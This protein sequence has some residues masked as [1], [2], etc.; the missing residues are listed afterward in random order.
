V[1]ELEVEDLSGQLEHFRATHT[2]KHY[3]VNGRTW[4]YLLGGQRNK[5]ALLLLPG[6]PGLGEMAFQHIMKFEHSYYV[7]SPNYP[8]GLTTVD[9]VIDD[10]VAIL[11]HEEIDAAHIVG[12]S[13]SGMITQC[14]L[15][16][17]PQRVRKI[18]L[19]HTSP[20]SKKMT[21]MYILYY[22]ILL[23][24]PLFCIRALLRLGNYFFSGR[25]T[26]QQA[27]WHSYFER[28]IIGGLTKED[29]LS[30]ARVCI[31][32]SRNYS[33]TS[34]DVHF[35]PGT[36][37]IIESDNDSFVPEEERARLKA[38]YPSARI[39]TFYGTGHVAWRNQS[40]TFFS[41]IASFLQE[42]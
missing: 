14:F 19:D 16:C 12:G 30:R 6:V 36:L 8:A 2:F 35:Q 3:N 7:I 39:Y 29:Y 21:R 40:D 18:V 13:Y 31:D 32:F 1:T 4:H 41:V 24:F 9:Q 37:L 10:I 42:V 27:F 38:L 22:L 11:D 25:E 23:L 26:P 28:D 17:Y 33:F 15:R 34:G 5:D 20:P